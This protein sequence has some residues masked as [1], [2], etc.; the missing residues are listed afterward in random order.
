MRYQ[1]LRRLMHSA[2]PA[3]APQRRQF[4]KTAAFA[5]GAALAR[6]IRAACSGEPNPIPHFFSAMPFGR[7]LHFFFPGAVEGV[8]QDTGHDPSLITDFNGVVGVADVAGQGIGKN[9]AT[10]AMVPYTYDADI[11]FMLGEFVGCDGQTRRGA[12]AFI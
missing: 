10:G 4:L 3:R 5:T 8:D 1:L 9:T 6:P 11:R 12:F 2:S 7:K